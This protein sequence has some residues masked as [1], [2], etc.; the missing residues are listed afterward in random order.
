M[1]RLTLETLSRK[2]NKALRSTK[3][4]HTCCF[5]SKTLSN[6]PNLKE[7]IKSVHFKTEKFL[8]DLCPKLYYTKR[9]IYHHLAENHREKKFKCNKCDLKFAFESW[10]ELHKT[11]HAVKVKCSICKKQV[12]SL[13]RHMI[14]HRPREK[15][16]ICLKMIRAADRRSMK[17][18]MKSHNK[19]C[20]KCGETFESRE[21]L[22]RWAL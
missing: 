9:S 3:D 10:L 19:K 16:P 6:L 17:S 20:G 11:T 8:C 4:P 22:R 12:S 13:R 1:E 2:G 21:A 5:C 7:H 14:T 15:C 18:H